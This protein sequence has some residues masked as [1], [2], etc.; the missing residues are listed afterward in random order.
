MTDLCAHILCILFVGGCILYIRVPVE[1]YAKENNKNAIYKTICLIELL[2]LIITYRA[3][4][5]L[6]L[7]C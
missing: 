1:N 5:S 2:G 7:N 6:E 3:H 4:V